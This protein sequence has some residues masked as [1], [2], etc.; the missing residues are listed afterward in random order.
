MGHPL[1]VPKL[2][3]LLSTLA[4]LFGPRLLKVIGDRSM[5]GAIKD[6]SPEAMPSLAR[7]GAASLINAYAY[8]DF[9][10]S[11]MDVI[12]HFNNALSSPELA[13]EQ[14]LTFQRFNE[15]V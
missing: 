8:K 4:K 14:A 13:A 1:K 3:S 15:A 10:L 12:T 2:L 11:T 9:P 6:E 7:E 5:M